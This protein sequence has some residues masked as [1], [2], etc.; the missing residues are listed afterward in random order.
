MKMD[1][2]KMVSLEDGRKRVL[3]YDY[4]LIYM[5]SEVI[6]E[7]VSQLAE[8]RWEECQEA[9]F[10]SEK[11]QLHFY[12]NE[13]DELTGTVFE[14]QENLKYRDVDYKMAER[15][16]KAYSKVTVREYLTSDNDGQTVVYYTRLFCVK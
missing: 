3:D 13:E 15:Y 9:F 14:E 1:C 8:I 11:G 12:R 16:K 10:F 2:V 7:P 6:F 5:M 4:A